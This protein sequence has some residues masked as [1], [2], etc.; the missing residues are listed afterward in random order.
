MDRYQWLPTTQNQISF[1]AVLHQ[2][3][4]GTI[5][6]SP[7]FTLYSS[8][9]VDGLCRYGIFSYQLLDAASRDITSPFPALQAEVHKGRGAGTGCTTRCA[10]CPSLAAGGAQVAGHTTAPSHCVQPWAPR[11]KN[12]EDLTESSGGTQR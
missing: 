10:P 11:Y 12:D 9:T 4:M 6:L 8:H 5:S 3:I 1:Y 2:Q 7:S